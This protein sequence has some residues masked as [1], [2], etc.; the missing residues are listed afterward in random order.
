MVTGIRDPGAGERWKDFRK[1]QAAPSRGV[2][3]FQVGWSEVGLSDGCWVV[4]KIEV[5]GRYRMQFLDGAFGGF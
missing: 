4:S 5:F 2:G 1:L 3:F